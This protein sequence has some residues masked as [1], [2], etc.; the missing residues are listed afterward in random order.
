MKWS[1]PKCDAWTWSSNYTI[2]AKKKGIK[3]EVNYVGKS[4]YFF[5]TFKNDENYNSLWDGLE[6]TRED[7]CKEACEKYID[8]ITG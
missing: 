1:K 7:E 8:M 6:Y 2:T 3:A 5:L 4:Y